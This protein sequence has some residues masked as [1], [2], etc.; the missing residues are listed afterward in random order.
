MASNIKKRAKITKDEMLDK[1]TDS[2]IG[3]IVPGE[4]KYYKRGKGKG[5]VKVEYHTEVDENAE[6]SKE[7]KMTAE[8]MKVKAWDKRRYNRDG[9][10]NEKR[11]KSYVRPDI[12]EENKEN[13]EQ[14][15]ASIDAY[16]SEQQNVADQVEGAEGKPKEAED[17]YTKKKGPLEKRN[18]YMRMEGMVNTVGRMQGDMSPEADSF[19]SESNPVQ[20]QSPNPVGQKLKAWNRKRKAKGLFGQKS[21]T[22]KAEF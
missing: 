7:M 22:I 16:R 13:P 18:D 1:V 11:S 4:K 17:S 19:Y 2:P 20:K 9:T 6:A 8:E 10:L 15:F 5:N 21:R 14:S 3:K 12:A